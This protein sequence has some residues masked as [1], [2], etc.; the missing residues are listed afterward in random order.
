M[1]SP[2]DP[3][4][5]V[6]HPDPYPFYADLVAHRPLYRDEALRLWVATSAAAVIAVLT[7]DLGRVRPLTEPVPAALLGSP[8]GEIFRHLVRM[9]DGPGHCPFKQAVSATLDSVDPAL[10]AAR[11]REWA[12]RIAVEPLADF[13]F[14]LPV[15]VTASL[16]GVPDGDL[17][18]TALRVSDLV[19]SFAPGAGPESLARGKMAAGHLLEFFR[20]L[21]SEPAP[22][23]LLGALG[24]EARR[25]GREDHD[26]I[27]A[28]AIGFLFQSHDA[29]AGLIGNTLV[30]LA[31]HPDVLAK[32][33]ADRGLLP[34]L[35]QEVLRFDPS[36]QNTRR[37]IARDGVVAGETMKEG[38]AILVVLAA[39]N[40]D[41][42]ANPRPDRFELHRQ[43]RQIFTFGAGIH[44]CP[45]EAI[46]TTIAQAGIDRLIDSRFDLQRF[47]AARVYRP[48]GNVRMPFGHLH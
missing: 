22:S 47:L 38:D 21:L 17:Y 13:A 29:T 8:A 9:N 44:A 37:F 48:S 25:V 23:G 26:V 39:A 1:T 19:A 36:V 41:P 35:L 33:T 15:Y 32:V 18:Q 46:A 28:N 40:R 30:T 3:I 45:G 14:H 31:S 4:A 43:D 6:T 7:S 42:A 27:A 5:A 12:A 2:S 20:G 16:L 34:Q 10:A 11:S 24:A